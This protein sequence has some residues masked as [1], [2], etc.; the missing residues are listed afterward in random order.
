MYILEPLGLGNPAVLVP[1]Q[2]LRMYVDG[3]QVNKPISLYEGQQLEVVVPHKEPS[4]ALL[5]QVSQNGL[6]AELRA[7]LE[8]GFEY[9]LRDSPHTVRLSLEAEL[10]HTKNPQRFTKRSARVSPKQGYHLRVD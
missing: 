7:E 6:E 2:T 4:R 5:L 3:V 9:G 10:K 1:G 8:D